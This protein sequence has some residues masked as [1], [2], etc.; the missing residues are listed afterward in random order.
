MWSNRKLRR[1]L[2]AACGL[3]L[4][5]AACQKIDE[6]PL[7]DP[8]DV[9]DFFADGQAARPIPAH[10][11]AQDEPLDLVLTSGQENGQPVAQMPVP[12]TADLMTRGQ[13][14]YNIYCTPCHGPLGDGNGMIVQR[15]F[16]QPPSFHTARLRQ[17]PDGMMFDVITNG[18]GIMYAYG[19]RVQPADRWAV[20]AYVRALQLSQGANASELPPADQQQLEGI[21]P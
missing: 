8:L 5:L 3:L 14:Q 9:S 13:E 1:M 10:A 12:V 7:H 19:S 17:M 6:Q 2:L 21:Q 20:I 18:F 16:P 11:V 4:A 15:G